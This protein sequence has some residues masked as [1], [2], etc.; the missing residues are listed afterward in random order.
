MPN[1]P[2]RLVPLD[3]AT[4]FRD[5]G[6]YE[7]TDGHHVR[8]DKLYRSNSLARLSDADL[9]VLRRLGIRLV[10][11]FRGDEEHEAAPSRVPEDDG[12]EILRL[13]VWPEASLTQR[14]MV[15]AGRIQV[16]EIIDGYIAV[17][18]A[19]ARHHG[20]AFAA[21]LHRLAEGASYPV[22]FH[23]SAGKDRT[24]FAA[25]LV[26]TAIGVPLE[27]VF[28]DYLL[29]NDLWAPLGAE[30]L[31]N[32]RFA[33]IVENMDEDARGA[34]LSA[35]PEYLQASLDAIHEAHGSFDAYFREGLGI[36]EET[37]EALRAALLE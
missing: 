2:R 14:M 7:T 16:D 28:A 34:Y 32:S 35:R 24:G 37:R 10:C 12:L 23:C 25:A 8:W 20:D 36:G 27:T 21:F 4:N 30:A 3:G 5:L 26:L 31:R 17:Y 11:D 19:F 22:V 18:R 1:N 6:G 29:T 9:D 13:P 33:A 15:M